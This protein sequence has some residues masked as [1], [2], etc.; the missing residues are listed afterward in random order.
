M[1]GVYYNEIDKFAAAWLRELIKA[2]LIPEGEVDERSITD[3]R[4]AELRP[5]RRWHFFAGIAGWERALQLAAWPDDRPIATGSCPCQPF[6]VAGQGKADND[7]RDLWPAF[8]NLIAECGF[9]TVFGEQVAGKLGYQW[10]AGVRSQLEGAGYRVGAACLPAC[11]VGAPHRRERLF[12]VAHAERATERGRW[13]ELPKEERQKTGRSD[14]GPRS[15]PS[16]VAHINGGNPS[17][18][19]EQRGGEQRFQPEGGCDSERMAHAESL[20]PGWR[21]DD[22]D[23][24]RRERASSDSGE[25]GV[26]HAPSERWREGRPEHEVRSGR[27]AAAGASGERM[28]RAPHD[29]AS[30]EQRPVSTTSCASAAGFWSDTEWLTGADGKTRRV[31]PGVRLLVN[32]FPNRVGRLRGYG[33]AIVPQVAAQFIEAAWGS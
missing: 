1:I 24:G 17:A 4:P 23:G 8:F 14:Y 9:P 15:D 32:G 33:N 28:G 10:L 18:E 26:E 12:W 21:A 16:F 20:G 13:R 11:A 31:K 5:F 27:D 22:E 2:Q 7:E 6:S 30:N 29:I 19:R 25:G 3:I